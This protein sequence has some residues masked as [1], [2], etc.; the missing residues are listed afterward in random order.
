VPT[1]QATL[2]RQIEGNLIGEEQVLTLLC[3]EL[4]NPLSSSFLGS[5]YGQWPR[6]GRPGAKFIWPRTGKEADGSPQA[7]YP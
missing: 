5:R 3:F 4:F 7:R 1:D 6:G 2:G